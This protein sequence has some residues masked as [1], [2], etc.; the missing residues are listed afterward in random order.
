M[1]NCLRGRFTGTNT[2][3]NEKTIRKNQ[4]PSTEKPQIKNKVDGRS[5]NKNERTLIIKRNDNTFRFY[6]FQQKTAEYF[7][8]N[9]PVLWVVKY[10][11]N[12][13]VLNVHWFRIILV[14]IN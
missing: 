11:K 9:N 2:L 10:N 3:K 1:L 14:I 13:L 8:L 12:I 4:T 7:I 5:D 6:C